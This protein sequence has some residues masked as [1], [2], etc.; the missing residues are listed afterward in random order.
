MPDTI[1]KSSHKRAIE[2][3]R[4]LQQSPRWRS[5]GNVVAVAAWCDVKGSALAGKRIPD[6]HLGNL[7]RPLDPKD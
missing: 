7:D 5:F 2:K 1:D 6:T 4:Q 3:L